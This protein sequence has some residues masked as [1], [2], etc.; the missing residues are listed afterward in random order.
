MRL[1]PSAGIRPSLAQPPRSVERHAA[2]L[3]LGWPVCLWMWRSKLITWADSSGPSHRPDRRTRPRPVFI[4]VS[5]SGWRRADARCQGAPKGAVGGPPP[6]NSGGD[7]DGG[8]VNPPAVAT[9]YGIGD[10][11]IPRRRCFGGITSTASI[12]IGCVRTAPRGTPGRGGAARDDG[13]R[14]RMLRGRSPR[15]PAGPGHPQHRWRDRERQD[16][17]ADGQREEVRRIHG[18]VARAAALDAA[19]Q[20]REGLGRR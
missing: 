16:H 2:R 14:H 19:G 6:A 11:R 12:S 8:E 15:G 3:P 1:W 13:P 18:I 10:G 7:G 20:Y 9:R 4:V 17:A 5:D